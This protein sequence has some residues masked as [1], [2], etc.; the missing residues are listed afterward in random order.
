MGG[1]SATSAGSPASIA[2][3]RLNFTNGS[4]YLRITLNDISLDHEMNSELEKST[5]ETINGIAKTAS[6]VEV[7]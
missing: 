1:A 7:V 3:L 5:E 4:K 6:A 2:T